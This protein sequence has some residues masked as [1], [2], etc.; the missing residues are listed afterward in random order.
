MAAGFSG[1]PVPQ[2][3]RLE[4]FAKKEVADR[5]SDPLTLMMAAL[6]ALH[7]GMTPA[8]SLNRGELAYKVAQ[9]AAPKGASVS[10]EHYPGL[11][12]PN[13]RKSGACWGGTPWA[14]L[15]HPCRGW[16]N[17]TSAAVNFLK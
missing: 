12:H 2:M 8:L 7:S 5:Q 4:E 3:P 10:G 11:N 17:Q 9:G 14:T 15:F 13:L 1:K 16:I 6:V